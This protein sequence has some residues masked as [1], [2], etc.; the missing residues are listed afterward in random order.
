MIAA[1]AGGKRTAAIEASPTTASAGPAATPVGTSTE[2]TEDSE[3]PTGC[4]GAQAGTTAGSRAA[5]TRTGGAR[6]VG[7]ANLKEEEAV[8]REQK[9][10]VAE[11]MET[12][13]VAMF[14]N[15]AAS[16]ELLAEG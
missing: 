1:E 2:E 3:V 12:A 14:D 11:K 8:R 10:H 7:G 5:P 4:R 9:A 6:P 16:E 13:Q 15:E